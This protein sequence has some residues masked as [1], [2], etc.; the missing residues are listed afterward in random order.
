MERG[1]NTMDVTMVTRVLVRYLHNSNFRSS[2]SRLTS[3][4]HGEILP[5]TAK[6]IK[7]NRYFP[8]EA[9]TARKIQRTR[10]AAAEL[11]SRSPVSSAAASRVRRCSKRQACWPCI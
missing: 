6:N 2:A 9:E 1:G 4:A 3:G 8:C 5:R 10:E 11:P 7:H